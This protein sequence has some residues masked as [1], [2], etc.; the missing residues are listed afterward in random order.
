MK[1]LLYMLLG[2]FAIGFI[3]CKRSTSVYQSNVA[4]ITSFR[5]MGQDSFPGLAAATFQVED[6]YGVGLIRVKDSI[7][8]GT[9]LT[10]VVP[11]MTF[12]ATPSSVV[13]SYG[14]PTTYASFTGSQAID[15]S[16][17]PMQVTVTSQDGSVTKTY[18]IQVYAHK[19]NPDL[20]VW[21]QLNPQIY[22]PT[23]TE[24]HLLEHGNQLKLF[25]SDGSKIDLYTSG[26]GETW[27]QQATNLPATSRIKQIF[28]EGDS[29]Y[30][31]S[32][33]N[34]YASLDGQTWLQRTA[35]T[36]INIAAQLMTMAGKTLL[37][38]NNADRSMALW[39][40]K[41]RV[42]TD[43]HVTL[44]TVKFPVSG[45]APVLFSRTG[46]RQQ[47]LVLGGYDRHGDMVNGIW[48]IEYIPDYSTTDQGTFRVANFAAGRI[49]ENIADATLLWYCNS[50]YKIGGIDAAGNIADSLIY[51]SKDEGISWA[52]ADTANIK[53]PTQFGKRYATSGLIREADNS[54][55]LVGGK[56][57]SGSL[58]DV[59]RGRLNQ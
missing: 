18:D 9:R 5:L 45:F 55:L 25:V 36:G 2:I 46:L 14:T 49:I 38:Q 50:L 27:T 53:L 52:V 10:S 39:S 13:F 8:Y 11:K 29:L 21:K 37:V 16:Q 47:G 7:K 23:N 31:L 51:V 17:T 1:K 22:T 42:F 48:N 20:V 40:W 4:Q 33:A 43:E 32:G 58:S 28:A 15:F 3:A 59:W 6:L 26:D 12:G 35:P 34:I 57:I 56:N 24:Q 44:D 41:N 30:Y 19:V 54:M